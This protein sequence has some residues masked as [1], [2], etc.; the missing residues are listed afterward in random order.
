[1]M[2]MCHVAPSSASSRGMVVKLL[3]ARSVIKMP[4]PDYTDD[5]FFQPIYQYLKEE[6]LTGNKE[7]DRK[8]TQAPA[9]CAPAHL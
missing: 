3:L 2:A 5:K 6:Q 9:L 7:T 1:M 8:T 4:P